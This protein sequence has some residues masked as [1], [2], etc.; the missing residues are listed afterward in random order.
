MPQN[1]IDW[2]EEAEGEGLTKVWSG[3]LGYSKDMLPLVGEIPEKDG[4][5]IAAGFS[6]HGQVGRWT[7]DTADPADLWILLHDNSLGSSHVPRA[8]LT[9]SRPVNGMNVFYLAALQ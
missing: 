4:L 7:I 2:G 6:G 3:I 9:R 5:F 8:W 1:F